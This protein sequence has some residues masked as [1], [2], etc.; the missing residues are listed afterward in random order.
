MSFKREV[1][2]SLEN[3]SDDEPLFLLRAQDQIAPYAITKWID[4][5]I[6]NGVNLKKRENAQKC[7]E[8]MFEWG[9]TN[10]TKVPD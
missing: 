1:L 6:V 9:R 8:D 4:L 2:E 5:S 3:I 10:F 7:K